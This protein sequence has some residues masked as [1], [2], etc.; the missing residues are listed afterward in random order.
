MAVRGARFVALCV[1]GVALEVCV[2]CMSREL[3]F[4]LAIVSLISGLALLYTTTLSA[5]VSPG[6]L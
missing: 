1:V 2:A 3:V 4:A 6:W 5:L